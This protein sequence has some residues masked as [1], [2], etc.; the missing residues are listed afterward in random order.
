M[1]LAQPDQFVQTSA[2]RVQ[3]PEFGKLIAR[4]TTIRVL[5]RCCDACH[6]DR[7]TSASCLKNALPAA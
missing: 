2:C 3:L 7:S 1:A 4:A 6:C 5:L